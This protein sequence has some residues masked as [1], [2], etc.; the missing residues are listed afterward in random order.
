MAEEKAYPMFSPEHIRA[1]IGLVCN[2]P[3]FLEKAAA[4]DLTVQYV[5][6]MEGASL[7]YRIAVEK[8]KLIKLDNELD[9]PFILSA[10]KE[11]WEGIFMGT[12]NPLVAIG[13]GK[14][15]L[16]K[17]QLMQLARWFGSFNRMFELFKEIKIERA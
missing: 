4:E 1:L 6:K 17:G 9:A 11:I 13:Q 7:S 5:I 14:I 10:P 3:L 2:D 12:L 15:K 16:E 8:G